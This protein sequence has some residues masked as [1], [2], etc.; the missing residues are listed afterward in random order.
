MTGPHASE[1]HR[2]LDLA[3]GAAVFGVYDQG[4]EGAYAEKIAIKAAIIARSIRRWP[5][6]VLTLLFG[7][8][9]SASHHRGREADGPT[10]VN[11]I[12]RTGRN[13]V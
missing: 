10:G 5:I 11:P 2:H 1:A 6:T 13:M 7:K 12:S 8:R 3:V 4:V 9:Y